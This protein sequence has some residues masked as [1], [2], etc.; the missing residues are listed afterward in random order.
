MEKPIYFFGVEAAILYDPTT[1]VP[2]GIFR[3]ISDGSFERTVDP[4]LLEG[5]NAAGPWAA[6]DGQPSNTLTLT[7]SEFQTFALKLL[8]NADVTEIEAEADGFVSGM[9]NSRGESVFNATT[10][11]VSVAVNPAGLSLL[12]FGTVTL[13]AISATT[14]RVKFKGHLAN[15]VNQYEDSEATIISDLDVSAGTTD[16]TEL[17]LT[18]TKGSGALALEVGDVAYFDVRPVNYGGEIIQVGKN[19]QTNVFGLMIV[20]PKNSNGDIITVDFP[21]VYAA[22]FNLGF[23]S[24]EYSTFTINGTPLVDPCN[25]GLLYEIKRIRTEQEAC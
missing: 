4:V 9:I 22:G 7:V 8:E 16:I 12:P 5:G 3:I 1:K 21:R 23:T 2:V 14:V 24:R 20:Y 17:G 10:G 19:P 25:D 15:G 11:L 6:E 13:E 18:I